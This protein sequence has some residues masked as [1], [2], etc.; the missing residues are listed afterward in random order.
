M[1][2]SNSNT[3]L[4]LI[5]LSESDIVPPSVFISYNWGMQDDAKLLR[6]YLERAGFPCWMDIGQMGGGDALYSKIYEGIRNAKVHMGVIE[7][8]LSL[9]DGH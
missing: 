7:G 1:I 8:R 6:D 2:T 5:F 4:F 9:L 3:I